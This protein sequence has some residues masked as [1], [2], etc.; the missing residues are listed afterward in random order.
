M[1]ERL[2]KMA[3]TLLKQEKGSERVKILEKVTQ[4]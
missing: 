1:T 3:D 4:A 2:L